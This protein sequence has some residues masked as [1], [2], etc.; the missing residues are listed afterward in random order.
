MLQ[1]DDHSFEG[2][3]QD[4]VGQF[5]LVDA[6]DAIGWFEKFNRQGGF[7]T[8]EAVAVNDHEDIIED[9]AASSHGAEFCSCEC[10]VGG[11]AEDFNQEANGDIGCHCALVFKAEAFTKISHG[12]VA[13][14]P[15]AVSGGAVQVGAPDLARMQSAQAC[16]GVVREQA[17]AICDGRG[18]E[19]IQHQFNNRVLDEVVGEDHFGGMRGIRRENSLDRY[20]QL[21]G[22]GTVDDA[23]VVGVRV[24]PGLEDETDRAAIELAALDV[25]GVA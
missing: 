6:A 7:K 15:G 17:C 25:H 1:A 8:A 11:V 24:V 4:V 18:E 9:T 22:E 20:F 19:L 14:L 3:L 13:E 21:I 16:E 23:H 2:T 5:E 10:R 12:V